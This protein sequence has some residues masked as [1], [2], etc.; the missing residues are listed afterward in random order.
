MNFITQY[1]MKNQYTSREYGIDT[2]RTKVRNCNHHLTNYITTAHDHMQLCYCIKSSLQFN[3]GRFL[4]FFLVRDVDLVLDKI[5]FCQVHNSDLLLLLGYFGG[6]TSFS[7]S[8]F[9]Q[10]NGFPNNFWGLGG[11]DDELHK[12]TKKVGMEISLVHKIPF[13]IVLRRLNACTIYRLFDFRIA[14]LQSSK[15]VYLDSLI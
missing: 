15:S 12:R 10:I 3:F 1:L 9:K 2:A 5:C 14:S 11:E 4:I 8:Q 6:I 7:V 13:C